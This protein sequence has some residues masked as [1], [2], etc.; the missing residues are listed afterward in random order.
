M[1]PEDGA[2]PKVF[3]DRRKWRE[4]PPGPGR[5]SLQLCG[6]VRDGLRAIFACFSDEVLRELTVV[7]VDPAPHAGRLMVTVAV[8]SPA[9][10]TDRNAATAH[11]VRATGLIRREIASGVH[12]RNTPEMVFR[13][14]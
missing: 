13:V 5:K 1:G 12:R 8:L 6:Q 4:K 2:D 9:D 7:S 11:L 10:A 3:H 14:I